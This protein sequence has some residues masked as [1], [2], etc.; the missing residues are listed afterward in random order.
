MPGILKTSNPNADIFLTAQNSRAVNT[1]LWGCVGGNMSAVNGPAYNEGT[2]MWESG[3]RDLLAEPF[4]S[5]FAAL[6]FRR[7][8]IPEGTKARFA[9]ALIGETDPNNGEGY[10]CSGATTCG[11]DAEAGGY[12]C[13]PWT[14]DFFIEMVLFAAALGDIPVD[15]VCD[16]HIDDADCFDQIDWM[17]SFGLANYIFL[18]LEEVTPS[19][20]E[21]WIGKEA[22]NDF[23]YQEKADNYVA[24]INTGL[25]ALQLAHPDVKI[26]ADTARPEQTGARQEIWT[27][28]LQVLPVN[29][30]RG[31]MNAND[32]VWVFGPDYDVNLEQVNMVINEIW[33]RYLYRARILFKNKKLA[34][35]QWG[36]QP[37]E[38]TEIQD[39]MLMCIAIAKMMRMMVNYNYNCD[40]FIMCAYYETG[41][42]LIDSNDIPNAAYYPLKAIGKMFVGTPDY[43]QLVLNNLDGVEGW[44]VK[45][46]STYHVLLINETDHQLNSS[47]LN[48]DGVTYTNFDRYV[49]YAGSLDSMTINE[50]SFPGESGI[51]LLETS[52]TVLTFTAS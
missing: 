39:T 36:F 16:T 34:M 8:S 1:D 17:I 52:I 43:I 12:C 49:V 14:T 27:S 2:M 47:S 21:Y 30:G 26:I 42:S 32:Q 13:V 28:Q 45:D 6:Q 35:A 33:P 15:Y 29:A 11:E 9:N 51:I 5:L 7:L 18:G 19:T 31:Y 24:Y 38:V 10:N 41:K 25:A 23:D 40:D 20:D 37:F 4:F 50:A 22:V 46:G 44:A 48:I 3:E